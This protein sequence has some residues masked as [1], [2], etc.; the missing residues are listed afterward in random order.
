MKKLFAL[1]MILGLVFKPAILSAVEEATAD[2]A[3]KATDTAISAEETAGEA[4]G[5]LEDLELGED[6]LAA[7]DE[8]AALDEETGA[9][10]DAAEA[11]AAPVAAAPKA[12]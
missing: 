12:Q 9:P 11:K 2:A 1:L 7:E 5:D 8:D 6:D 4:G 10:K 3:K